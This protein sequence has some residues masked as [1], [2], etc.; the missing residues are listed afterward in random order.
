MT[1]L[2]FLIILKHNSV[3]WNHDNLKHAQRLRAKGMCQYS[4][5]PGVA[6]WWEVTE[7]GKRWVA[8]VHKQYSVSATTA[9]APTRKCPLCGM[10]WSTFIEV[11][12]CRRQGRLD[13]GGLGMS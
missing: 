6:G 2:E 7:L 10:V 4:H 3:Q 9:P 11:C 5:T 8:E 1:D 13:G 12:P